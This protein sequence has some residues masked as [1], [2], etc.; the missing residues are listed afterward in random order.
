[1][2]DVALGIASSGPAATGPGPAGSEV[3]DRSLEALRAEVRAQGRLGAKETRATR[4]KQYACDRELY[5]IAN[6]LPS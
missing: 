4:K 3:V 1:M 5:Q 6:S 2:L